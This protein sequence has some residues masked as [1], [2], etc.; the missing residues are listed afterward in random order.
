MSV[1]GI[2]QEEKERDKLCKCR[3]CGGGDDHQQQ[4]ER[5]EAVSRALLLEPAT[6]ASYIRPTGTACRSS[7]LIGLYFVD[8]LAV[9]PGDTFQW[10]RE[11]TAALI[12][13]LH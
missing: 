12:P 3:C 4:K 10:L 1:E 11:S 8:I 7:G 9:A 6:A 5:Q 13:L 2:Q